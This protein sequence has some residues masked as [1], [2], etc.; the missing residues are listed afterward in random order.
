LLYGFCRWIWHYQ[1]IFM[2]DLGKERFCKETRG[3]LFVTVVTGEKVG[4]KCLLLWGK[5]YFVKGGVCIAAL[6]K[7]RRVFYSTVNFLTK[8]AESVTCVCSDWSWKMCS[9]WLNFDFYQVDADS[10]F[11]LIPYCK[12]KT[13]FICYKWLIP[14]IGKMDLLW[15]ARITV[16]KLAHQLDWLATGDL[17]NPSSW[18]EEVPSSWEEEVPMLFPILYSAML[19][20]YWIQVVLSYI[21]RN[22]KL[23]WLSFHAS[24]N[25]RHQPWKDK[26]VVRTCTAFLRDSGMESVSTY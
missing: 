26:S 22:V 4:Y 11:T 16:S 13:A 18:E 8:N 21:S 7:L 15:K 1:S 14:W 19:I 17:I 10:V 6:D 25:K 3:T 2:P 5:S 24:F 20:Y 12:C 23:Q 9:A